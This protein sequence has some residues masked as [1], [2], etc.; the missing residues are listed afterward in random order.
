MIGEK[1]MDK[2][3]EYNKSYFHQCPLCLKEVN[4]NEEFIVTITKGV[5][6]RHFAHTSCFNK[7]LKRRK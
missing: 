1:P 7:L 4:A 6:K 2:I 3:K 5:L